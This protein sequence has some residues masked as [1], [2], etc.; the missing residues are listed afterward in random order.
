MGMNFGSDARYFVILN[1]KNIFHFFSRIEILTFVW[2]D[3]TVDNTDNEKS[4]DQHGQDSHPDAFPILRANES[5]FP[6]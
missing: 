3:A 4:E 6:R 2:Y 1:S 5:S